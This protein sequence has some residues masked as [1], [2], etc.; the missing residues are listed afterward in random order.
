MSVNLHCLIKRIEDKSAAV[1]KISVKVTDIC[2]SV[3]YR[4]IC[5]VVPETGGK[6]PM[7][8]VSG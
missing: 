1:I 3:C 5:A 6:I 4:W 2:N 8:E 7:T